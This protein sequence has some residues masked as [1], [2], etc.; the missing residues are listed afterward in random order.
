MSQSKQ[1]ILAL[2][3]EAGVEPRHRFGQHFMIDQN[4]VRAVAA[5]GEPKP[6]DLVLEV[7]PGTGTLTE[8][9]LG[10]G[11]EVL[12][13]EIDR[14]MAALLRSRLGDR[15]N[16]SLMEADALSSKHA[17]NA[18]LLARIRE[19]LDA[20]RAVHLIANLPYNVASPLIVE[21]LH[22]GVARLAFTV[23]REVAMRLRAA[24]GTEEYGALSV[25]V[26]MLARVRVLRT[27]PP[28]A[29]WPAPA[30]ESA[31]VRI[32]RQDRLG[33]SAGAFSR[34]VAGLFS[35]RRK[36][37]RK[38]LELMGYDA[39]AMLSAAGI[40]GRLRPEHL[41]PEELWRLFSQVAA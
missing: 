30:V 40:D 12:A 41:A 34:F 6:G 28:Q 5:A 32:D 3:A 4:L 8:E 35:S 15:P 1:Q 26:Q 17:L 31:L 7:G 27:L 39:Q 36:T 13:V 33:E 24:P 23:Q 19:A 2:L 25:V 14:D 11:A 16:F 22:A 21:L 9:L 29:F 37:L 38:G 10:S 18:Q 20:G